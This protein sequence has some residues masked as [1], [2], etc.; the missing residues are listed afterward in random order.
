[1]LTSPRYGF[2]T[3]PRVYARDR[4][5]RT[6]ECL[7]NSPVDLPGKTPLDGLYP[8]LKGF[9][10]DGLKVPIMT[11]TVL[12]KQLIEL[13]EARSP[14]SKDSKRLTTALGQVLG[15]DASTKID[16][17]TWDKLKQSAF[18]PVRVPGHGTCLKSIKDEFCIND[19]KRY[20][21]AFRDKAR[22]LDFEYEDMGYIHPLLQKL[23][24]TKRY[25][26]TAVHLDT[27]YTGATLND[28]LTRQ[29]RSLAYALSWS[30]E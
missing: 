1:V 6:S 27:A 20:G 5:Y 10:V 12:V 30:V 14:D 28:D 19:H 16:A 25:L 17:T 11:P 2:D 18:L 15:R 26:S 24:L 13:A 7:W 9:F 29:M 23:G 21:E 4:W 22:I 3:H 8:T